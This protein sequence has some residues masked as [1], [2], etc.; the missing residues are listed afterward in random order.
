[1]TE[2]ETREKPPREETM[3]GG[4]GCTW[5]CDCALGQGLLQSSGGSQTRKSED[6][7]LRPDWM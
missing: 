6:D 2:I 1:M 7:P 4:R 5:A 3:G